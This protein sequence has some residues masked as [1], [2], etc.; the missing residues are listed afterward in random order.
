LRAL[1][2]QFSQTN[3][4]DTNGHTKAIGIDEN[5][6]KK[7]VEATFKAKEVE[8]LQS[9]NSSESTEALQRVYGEQAEAVFAL[10]ANEYGMSKEALHSLAASNPK[11][12]KTL[13]GIS[14]SKAPAD[15]VAASSKISITNTVATQSNLPAWKQDLKNC[16]RASVLNPNNVKQLLSKALGG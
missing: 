6:V 12:F 5:E 9:R 1:R 8:L 16:D 4:Q 15:S 11:A 10:K 14:E 3:S 2:E 13:M 7:M